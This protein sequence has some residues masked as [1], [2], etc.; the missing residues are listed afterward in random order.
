MRTASA[1]LATL[2]DLLSSPQSREH[3]FL[4]A[5]QETILVPRPV[6]SY[7]LILG[8]STLPDP[9]ETASICHWGLYLNVTS[10]DSPSLNPQPQSPPLFLVNI[11][12]SLFPS[13]NVL[14]ESEDHCVPPG[15][16]EVIQSCLTLCDSIGCSLPGSSVH[17][18][19]PGKNTGASR[20]S[21][22]PRDWTQASWVVSR[23]FTV[24]ATGEAR[25]S[26]LPVSKWV[27]T[28]ISVVVQGLRLQTFTV[29]GTGSIPSQ[30]SKIPHLAQH[31]KKN[32]GKHSCLPNEWWQC[33]SLE[34]ALWK[35]SWEKP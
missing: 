11:P 10:W 22:Q 19:S 25:A 28:G 6:L 23:H 2:S 30:G 20:G 17:G 24:W 3:S 12:K 26:W 8:P 29:G 18:D 4:S 33:H 7:Y 32:S 35:F 15:W 9:Q 5:S 34:P 1:G 27:M 13:R 31:R 21:S 14:H 16:S